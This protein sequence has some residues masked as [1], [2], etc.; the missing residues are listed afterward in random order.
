MKIILLSLG[1]I[2]VLAIQFMLVV[3]IASSKSG[4]EM[5][6]LIKPKQHDTRTIRK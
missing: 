1:A 2:A 5:N 3:A 6:K 4:K